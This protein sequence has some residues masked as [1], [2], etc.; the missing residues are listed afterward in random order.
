MEHALDRRKHIAFFV[1]KVRPGHGQRDLHLSTGGREIL[2]GL[3]LFQGHVQL[4]VVMIQ[5]G[6]LVA[7]QQNMIQGDIDQVAFLLAVIME[8]PGH[9]TAHQSEF[10]QG[11]EPGERLFDLI[12]EGE[13]YL[14]LNHQGVNDVRHG[15]KLTAPVEKSIQADSA[16]SARLRGA[17][18]SSEDLFACFDAADKVDSAPQLGKL[19]DQ[20]CDAIH[21]KLGFL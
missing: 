2:H 21:L 3:H 6:E 9:Q 15:G 17:L 19:L 4:F 1:V 18:I 20:V 13:E 10:A 7:F 16:S 14:V 11:L 8:Q 5:A 12:K